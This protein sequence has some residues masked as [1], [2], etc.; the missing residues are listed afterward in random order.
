M[1]VMYHLKARLTEEVILPAI[2][3]VSKIDRK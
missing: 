1:S 2:Y 3:R